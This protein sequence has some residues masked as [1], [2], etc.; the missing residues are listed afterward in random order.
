MSRLSFF[1]VAGMFAGLAGGFDAPLPPIP[2]DLDARGTPRATRGIPGR[3]HWRKTHP[4]PIPTTERPTNPASAARWD[5][6]QAKR[7]RRAIKAMVQRPVGRKLTIGQLLNGDYLID[8]DDR[9]AGPVNVATWAD[10]HALL[11]LTADNLVEQVM[12]FRAPPHDTVSWICVVSIHNDTQAR[13]LTTRDTLSVLGASRDPVP[14]RTLIRGF[15]DS[16]AAE[17]DFRDPCPLRGSFT[18]KAPVR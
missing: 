3:R 16:L 10:L 9:T 13:R 4:P 2:R 7:A 17:P 15:L 8:F 18:I 11:T 5:A 6:A 14:L 1:A 12:P